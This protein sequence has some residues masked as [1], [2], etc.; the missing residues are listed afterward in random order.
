MDTLSHALW[1][2]G[3]F[4]FRGSSK[5]A[6]FFGIMPDL[7]SFGLLFI[8]K[9]F[10][11]DLNYKGPLTLDSL[12]QLKPYP[13]WLFFM[14]NLS[15]S[16][17]IC[18]LFIGIT[19]FFKKEIV[20]PMLAWPFHIIL[21]FPFHTKD[22]FPVKIFWPFSNYHYDGVSWSSPEVWIPNCAGLI[23]LFM[24]R[25]NKKLFKS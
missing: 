12:E 23:L 25:Y 11:G 6:I 21:D 8:V 9:F 7:A 14:D 19:Y 15:H 3:L 16:F 2:K 13:E 1:G 10:S 18:F 5:L 17:I 4:G 22:F 20:W 24:Y